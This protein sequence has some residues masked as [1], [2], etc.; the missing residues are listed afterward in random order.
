MK[1]K[2]VIY[3][4]KAENEYQAM[5]PDIVGGWAIFYLKENGAHIYDGVSYAFN[6]PKNYVQVTQKSLPL[7]VKK[8]INKFKKEHQEL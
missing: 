4:N 6:K 5:I 8:K 3:Y 2:T 1:K 7:A